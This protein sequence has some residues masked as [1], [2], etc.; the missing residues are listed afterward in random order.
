[1]LRRLTMPAVA[2][3]TLAAQTPAPVEY[4]GVH[5]QR[6]FAAAQATAKKLELPLV[7]L[8]QEVPG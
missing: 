1:M 4:G 3:A 8:L 2:A 7:V 5:W 6:D